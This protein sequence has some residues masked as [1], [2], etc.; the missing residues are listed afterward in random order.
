MKFATGGK[1]VF[2]DYFHHAK[3]KGFHDELIEYCTSNGQKDAWVMIW[4][5]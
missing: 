3:G 4:E 2:S 5:G 1:D